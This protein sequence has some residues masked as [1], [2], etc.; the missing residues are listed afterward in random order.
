MFNN[1]CNVLLTEVL[2]QVLDCGAVE[3]IKCAGGNQRK[4]LEFTLRD[5]K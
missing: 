5:I 2:G 4:K 3:T 1:F